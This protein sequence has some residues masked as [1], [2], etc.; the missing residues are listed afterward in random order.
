MSCCRLRVHKAERENDRGTWSY[1]GFTSKR[2]VYQ[3]LT[4]NVGENLVLLAGGGE[5]E[6][7]WN[8][9]KQSAL[10]KACPQEKL[11][12]QSPTCPVFISAYLTWEKGNTIL[13]ILSHLRRVE[14]IW[15]GLR[16]NDEVHRFTERP[17]QHRKNTEHFASSHTSPPHY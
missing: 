7:S 2:N 17:R 4:V 13:P 11:V 6:P 14:G 1:G 10:N 9:P 15:V 5:K 12:N 16:N 3:G 8:P